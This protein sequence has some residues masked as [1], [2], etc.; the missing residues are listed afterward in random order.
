MLTRVSELLLQRNIGN[1][2]GPQWWDYETLT[3][4]MYRLPLIQYHSLFIASTIRELTCSTTALLLSNL[5]LLFLSQ[6]ISSLVYPDTIQPTLYAEYWL[7]TYIFCELPWKW[8]EIFA[9][10][11]FIKREMRSYHE[12]QNQ[13]SEQIILSL[14]GDSLSCSVHFFS[15]MS[16]WFDNTVWQ[17]GC[18]HHLYVLLVEKVS[19]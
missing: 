13:S 6:C 16:F 11:Y 14:G 7:L 1:R 15:L 17:Y 5:I 2:S 8:R 4:H 18:Q 3:S 19:C 9:L 12:I 10:H